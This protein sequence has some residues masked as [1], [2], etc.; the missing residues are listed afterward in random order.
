[1]TVYYHLHRVTVRL[2]LVP[3]KRNNSNGWDTT[4]KKWINPPYELAMQFWFFDVQN[5][6]AVERHGHKPVLL[7]RGPYGYT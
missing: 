6:L 1:M 5:P 4:T 2:Q 3:L 7:Q